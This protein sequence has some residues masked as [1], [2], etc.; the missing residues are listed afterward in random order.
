M[1]IPSIT[2]HRCT[3]LSQR[4]LL[5]LPVRLGGL[6]I[7]NPSQDADLQYQASMKT[8]APLVEKIVSQAHE[9][10][11][12]AIVS[13]LQQSVQREKNEVLQTKLNEYK[14]SFTLKTQHAVELA[15]EKGACN[16]LTVITI[17]EMG[18]VLNK[19]EFRD[20]LK[21]RYDW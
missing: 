5:A 21:L 6:G 18:F 9:T 20:A 17:D 19:G 8:A 1:L 13:S 3:T 10:P 12:D 14:I 16:W 7:I 4:N 15:S 11:D 2:D